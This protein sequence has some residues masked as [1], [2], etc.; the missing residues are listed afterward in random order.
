MYAIIELCAGMPYPGIHTLH[1]GKKASMDL[2]KASATYF[3]FGH[4]FFITQKFLTG[5]ALKFLQAVVVC[6]CLHSE[7]FPTTK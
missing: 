2:Q 4:E 5:N 6:V 7:R 1:A 3:L